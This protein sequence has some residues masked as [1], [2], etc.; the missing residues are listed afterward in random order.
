MNKP[1]LADVGAALLA[2]LVAF[3]AIA[4]FF[5]VFPSR[6]LFRGVEAF[7]VIFIPAGVFVSRLM[8]TRRGADGVWLA[9]ALLA[10]LAALV[11][12]VGTL[13]FFYVLPF[14]SWQFCAVAALTIA[15]LAGCGVFFFSQL[16]FTRRGAEWS[17]ASLRLAVLTALPTASV[18]FV[19][20]MADPSLGLSPSRVPVL[21]A[22][23]S[24]G[25]SPSSVAVLA[26]I[27]ALFGVLVWRLVSTRRGSK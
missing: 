5:Y 26:F 18:A 12:Y 27:L 10:L 21:M 23:P 13:G 2:A 16:V 4:A 7:A 14:S 1:R 6:H 3:F 17:Y 22:D 15:I 20:T 11:A 9:R 25:L 19:V 24:L 8:S